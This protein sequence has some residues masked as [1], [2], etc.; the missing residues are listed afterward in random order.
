MDSNHPDINSLREA[1]EAERTLR[2]EAQESQKRL[3]FIAR[4]SE[5]LSTSLDYQETL[6]SVAA[7]VVPEVADWFAV[8]L[9][10]QGGEV[11]RLAVQH[12]DPAKIRFVEDLE[13]EYP[14][15]KSSP[16]GVYEVMRTGKTIHMDRIPEALLRETA[17]DARHLELIEQLGLVSV[18]IAPLT[19]RGRVLGAITFVHAESGRLYDA[20]DVQ[21]LEDLAHRAGQAIDNARL[22]SELEMSH[23]HLEEQA[24]EL[25]MQATELEAQTAELETERSRF[26]AVLEHAPIGIVIAEAPEGR[27]VFGNRMAEV[28]LRHPVIYSPD[29]K[30]YDRWVAFRENGEQLKGEEFALARALSTGKSVGPDE[31]LYQRGDGT[32]SW[33]RVSGAPILDGKDRVV[34]S[35]VT[36]TDIDAERRLRDERELLIGTIAA[37]RARLRDI[38]MQTPAFIAVL[39]GPD[40]VFNIVNGPYYQLVGHR[41]VLGK[42]VAEALP[43]VI[44]QGFIKMLDHVY[45]T[46]EPLNGNEVPVQLQ[47][48]SDGTT[49]ERIVNFVYQPLRRIDGT[50]E[51]IVAHG[52]DVTEQVMARRAVEGANRAKS[53]FLATMSHELRTPLNAILGYADLLSAGLPEA[54]P[55]ADRPSIDRIALS[56]RHLLGLIEEILTFSRIE[57][58]RES[59]YVTATDLTEIMAEVAAIGEPLTAARGL[60]FK[61]TAPDGPVVVRTDARKLRQ[62]LLNLVGNAVKFTD[63]GHIEIELQAE[64]DGVRIMV[65]DTGIGIAESDIEQIFQPFWQVETDR[66]RR[67]G[68]TGLG[69]TVSRRLAELLGGELRVESKVGKGTTFHVI[70]PRSAPVNDD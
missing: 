56:A 37:E 11:M 57:A 69:L 44:E 64:E 50:I 15:D 60:G 29:V 40:H 53:D 13:R 2:I 66:T 70:L 52:V 54:I 42:P 49:E 26:E 19:A 32:N 25:E 20:D 51:G 22:V 7:L 43:E 61:V 21:E 45:R 1:Y 67:V 4:A 23:L 16:Y 34:A 48:E 3:R 36:L 30:S 47:R 38:F 33:V 18:I 58:G 55:E 63:G 8:D 35:L 27:I 14:P 6:R 62:V 65:C 28:I 10:D 9:V 31:Y 39:H 12:S 46:G 5:V 68:G 17:V 59:L 41:E 24:G